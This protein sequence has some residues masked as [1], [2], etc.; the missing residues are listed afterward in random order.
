MT[1][2]L[3]QNALL[4]LPPELAHRVAL[5]GLN[6]LHQLSLLPF[7]FKPPAASPVQCFGLSFK[8]P[9]GLA[10]GLDKNADYLDALG[11]LGFGF[12]E[13]GTVTPK[14]QTGNPRPRLFRLRE[15]LALINRMGFNNEGQAYVLRRLE[16]SKYDGILGVNIGKNKDTPLALASLDYLSGFHAFAER[17]DYI[18]LNISSPNTP[19]LRDLQH[20]EALTALLSTLKEAQLKQSKYVPLILKI[21]PDLSASEV[22]AIAD[23]IV[24]TEIDGVI[25]TNTTLSREGIESSQYANE[26]GGLSGL[27]LAKKSTAAVATLAKA[28]GGKRPIIACGGIQSADDLI[29]KQKAGATLFQV[30]TGFIYQGPGLIRSLTEA[31]QHAEERQGRVHLVNT[32]N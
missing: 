3:L 31:I 6:A 10:A 1:T 25:A 8:N 14:P 5:S 24:K 7:F 32:K 20:T 21:S 28:L 15:H 11:A 13:I 26:V 4:T 19:G 18:T 29:A 9:I 17:A 16:K 30:Y 2:R 27:P 12:I 22:E 23:V